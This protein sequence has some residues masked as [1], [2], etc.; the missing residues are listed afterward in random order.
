MQRRGDDG[1]QVTLDL[2]RERCRLVEQ[3]IH[4]EWTK[5]SSIDGS[6]VKGTGSD[7]C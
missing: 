3:W 2:A 7:R 6:F 5:L 1:G 4:L